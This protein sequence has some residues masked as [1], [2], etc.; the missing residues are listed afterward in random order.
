MYELEISRGGISGRLSG[1]NW[2]LSTPLL[3]RDTTLGLKQNGRQKRSKSS[4][5][6]GK[7]LARMESNQYFADG[8]WLRD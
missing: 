3:S 1:I 2:A 6:I 4:F 5:R 8:I 7:N